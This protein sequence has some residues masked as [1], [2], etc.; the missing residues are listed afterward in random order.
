MRGF[1]NSGRP[2]FVA[3]R[4]QRAKIEQG[5]PRERYAPEIYAAIY[6]PTRTQE[7]CMSSATFSNKLALCPT[8]SAQ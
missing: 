7:S 1:V 8:E 6:C 3:T 5:E 4:V 2:L